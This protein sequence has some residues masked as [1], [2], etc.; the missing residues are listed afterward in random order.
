MIPTPYLL[1]QIQLNDFYFKE[2]WGDTACGQEGES[3]R[4]EKGERN[5]AD[6]PV[7]M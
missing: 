7:Y 6:V 1:W 5:K 2:G 4:N 3:D